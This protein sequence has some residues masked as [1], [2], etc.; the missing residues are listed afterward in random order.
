M[1]RR[2][3]DSPDLTDPEQNRRRREALSYRHVVYDRVPDDTKWQRW[4][5]MPITS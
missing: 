1:D 3:I 4:A 5:P 2:L